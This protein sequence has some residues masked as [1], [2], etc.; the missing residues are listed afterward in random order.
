V[1]RVRV[2]ELEV[3]PVIERPTTRW[4]KSKECVG[5]PGFTRTAEAIVDASGVEMVKELA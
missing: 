2:S 4:S 5:D 3:E 1:G